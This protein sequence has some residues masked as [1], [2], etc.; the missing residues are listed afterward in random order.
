M[1]RATWQRSIDELLKATDKQIVSIL[2]QDGLLPK[3]SG[4]LAP[5][6][7]KVLGASVSTT[8]HPNINALIGFAGRTQRRTICIP[9][10]KSLSGF[11]INLYKRRPRCC[12][13]CLLAHPLLNADCFWD[14]ITR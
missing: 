2:E 1:D 3:W 10:S 12:F 6:V 4:H 13:F 14:G 9:F 7:G 8:T 11:S 5:A